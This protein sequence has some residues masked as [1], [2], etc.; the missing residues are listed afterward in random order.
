MSRT[1]KTRR[2]ILFINSSLGMG[3]IETLLLELCRDMKTQGCYEPGICIFETEGVL[4]NEYEALGVPV[5]IIPKKP[6]LDYSLPFKIRR[7]IRKEHYDLVHV[8]NQMSWLYGGT[9]AILARRPLVYTE[10][11]SLEK[12]TPEQQRKLKTILFWIGRKTAQVTT[13][14]KHLIPSLEK[15]LGIP[16]DRITNIYNGIDPEPYQLEIDR[17]RKLEELG[18]PAD[19]RVVGIVASLT[20]AKD[21]VTLLRAFARV[22]QDVPAAQLL[23]AGQGPLKEQIVA[24]TAALG[25]G[26]HVHFL[27]VRRDIPELLQVFDIFTLSSLIEGLPISLLEAMASGCPIVATRIPG[28]DELVDEK[29]GILVPHSHPEELAAALVRV[30]VD[31]EL[32]HSLGNGGRQRILDEFSFEGMI[33]AYLS[34]YDKALGGPCGEETA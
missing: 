33:K 34:C 19:S 31:D 29:S 9:G 28:V 15:D 2:K 12:F 25:I 27:G 13:V 11:T 16:G 21:H 8:H 4:Q 32:A 17:A 10:H 6:G 14:A 30:L 1:G 18:L 20:Q 5:Y 3:G 7:L 22:L 26:G 24:E 23:V